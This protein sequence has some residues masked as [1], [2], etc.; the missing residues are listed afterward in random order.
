MS[1]VRPKTVFI[2]IDGTINMKSHPG[3]TASENW[4]LPFTIAPGIHDLFDRLEK[5]GAVIVI[6]TARPESQRE[7]V[8]SQLY[9]IGLWWDHLIMGLNS[10]PRILI[11]DNMCC[12]VQVQLN[13]GVSERHVNY[14]F[15][16]QR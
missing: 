4:F 9:T 3:G 10:G 2:D 8:A 7:Y 13:A 16:E 15:R 14:I 11:D 5:E 12:A 1:H 6:I